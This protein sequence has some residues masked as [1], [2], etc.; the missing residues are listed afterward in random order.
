MLHYPKS[1][2]DWLVLRHQYISSTESAAL[3]GLGDYQTPYEIG[4]EKQAKEPPQ[5]FEANTRVTWGKRLQEVIAKGISVDYGVKVRR[6]NGYAVHPTSK[7]GASFDYEIVGV[8]TNEDGSEVKVEDAMLQEMYK[9]LGAGVLEIKAVDALIF[10][11]RWITEDKEIEAPPQIEIQLQ[12]QLEAIQTRKW[13]AIGVLA[14]GNDPY[15]VIRER[16]EDFGQR[17]REVV[18][19]FWLELAAG[20]LPPVTLPA[21]IEIIRQLYVGT[22]G[23]KIYMPGDEHEAS[24]LVDICAEYKKSAEMAKLYEEARKTCG[25][26][27]IQAMEDCELLNLPGYRVKASTVSETVVK[28]FT[29]K[30]FRKVT[31]TELN[32]S[33]DKE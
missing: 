7:L 32:P 4:L 26:R 16:Q 2:A 25:A 9:D 11:K 20:R 12:H 18:D 1:E 22:T 3:L 15:V 6:V 33:E 30:A 28:A 5:S 13:G 29:R 27:L 8:A 10:R 21:D 31:I 23:G 17:I 14:G 19:H 24:Q